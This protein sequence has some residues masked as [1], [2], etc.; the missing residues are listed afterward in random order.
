MSDFGFYIDSRNRTIVECQCGS[1]VVFDP[2]SAALSRL[3]FRCGQ[4]VERPFPLEREEIMDIDYE[5]DDSPD[6]LEELNDNEALDYTDE[7]VTNEEVTN[8]NEDDDDLGRTKLE[9]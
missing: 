6:D 9:L 4:Q 7:E 2:N 1:F 3:C 8:I 5:R